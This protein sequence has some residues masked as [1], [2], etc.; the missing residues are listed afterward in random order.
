MPVVEYML[1][2]HSHV[3]GVSVPCSNVYVAAD[4][5][6]RQ[7]I[8]D[9]SMTLLLLLA[10]TS[11]YDAATLKLR[12]SRCLQVGVAGSL[13]P[14]VPLC[15]AWLLLYVHTARLH[16]QGVMVRRCCSGQIHIINTQSKSDQ[17]MQGMKQGKSSPNHMQETTQHT[18]LN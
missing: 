15:F 9:Y 13:K 5:A 12:T 11:N 18:C 16:G 10:T 14:V 1:D 17:W 2:V 4:Q 3:P 7:T 8:H 6:L